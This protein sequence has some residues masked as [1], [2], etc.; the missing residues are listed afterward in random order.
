MATKVMYVIKQIVKMSV[1]EG[2]AFGDILKEFH[3][4]QEKH[5]GN[6]K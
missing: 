2:S 1:V 6:C 3:P 5:G 4:R